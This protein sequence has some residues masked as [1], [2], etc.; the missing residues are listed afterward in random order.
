MDNLDKTL[1]D[2]YSRKKEYRRRDEV[3]YHLPE[4]VHLM[5]EY[6][7]KNYA[8]KPLPYEKKSEYEKPN[9]LYN[10]N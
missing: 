10:E 1:K 6:F 4:W 8:Q 3:S 5:V 9:K 7:N 2:L